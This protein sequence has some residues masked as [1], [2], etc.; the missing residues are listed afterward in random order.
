MIRSDLENF[1]L[2]C[3]ETVRRQVMKRRAPQQR[4]T[5]AVLLGSGLH[6]YT[7][8]RAEDKQHILELLLTHEKLLVYL[9]QK[10]FPTHFSSY[11]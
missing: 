5:S 7:V 8:F 1:F 9:Y 11:V 10:I 6:D 3:V 2:E 4:E